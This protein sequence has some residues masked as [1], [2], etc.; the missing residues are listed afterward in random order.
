MFVN[1][2]VINESLYSPPPPHTKKKDK[3]KEGS[4]KLSN[5][6]RVTQLATGRTTIP[7][8]SSETD[9]IIDPDFLPFV[10]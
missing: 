3:G 1:Q 7:K 8:K 4:E 10:G 6:L 5:L 2:K 9:C